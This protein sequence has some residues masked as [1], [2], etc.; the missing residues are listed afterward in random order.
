MRGSSIHPSI[1]P[2]EQRLHIDSL[3]FLIL[4]I[5]SISITNQWPFFT[6]L[7]FLF[8]DFF[9]IIIH[10][11]DIINHTYM[12]LR[13]SSL[14]SWVA[15]ST[16]ISLFIFLSIHKLNTLPDR[17]NSSLV[18]YR[19]STPFLALA[20]PARKLRKS[21]WTHA[22][23]MPLHL[24]LPCFSILATQR[25]PLQFLLQPFSILATQRFPFRP[26]S[27]PCSCILLQSL[28][29]FSVI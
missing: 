22:R 12:F 19:Y 29:P 17:E 6:F 5:C 26:L 10:L 23:T 9:R 13:P 16:Q 18:V 11:H 4:Y 8:V 25:F 27:C 20:K 1:H 28:R 3:S 15:P 24:P 14:L 7:F 21:L 2:C